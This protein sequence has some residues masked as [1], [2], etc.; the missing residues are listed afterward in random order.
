MFGFAIAYIF[1][2]FKRRCAPLPFMQRT[3][4]ERF[5]KTR[6]NRCFYINFYLFSNHF[7]GNYQK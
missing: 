4:R 5:F 2:S 1:R 6:E 7:K 3:D